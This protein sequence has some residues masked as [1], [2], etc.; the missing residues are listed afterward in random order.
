MAFASRLVALL[1]LSIAVLQLR[2]ADACVVPYGGCRAALCNAIPLVDTIGHDALGVINQA[3]HTYS[4]PLS[5]YQGLWNSGNWGSQSLWEN[6]KDGPYLNKE[7][8]RVSGA[9]VRVHF[10]SSLTLFAASFKLIIILSAAIIVSYG[11]GAYLF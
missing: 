3:N 1:A 2:T 8:F 11:G 9:A 5:F 4:K 7:N 10:Q 6:V